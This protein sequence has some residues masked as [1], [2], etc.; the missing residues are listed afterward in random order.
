MNIDCIVYRTGL[1]K[2][3]DGKPVGTFQVSENTPVE[4]H[5]N[6]IIMNCIQQCKIAGEK[7]PQFRVAFKGPVEGEH[8]SLDECL[9]ACS[10][11]TK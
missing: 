1:R 4:P 3:P 8:K 2:F 11:K 5:V 9:K 10:P 6:S 7:P